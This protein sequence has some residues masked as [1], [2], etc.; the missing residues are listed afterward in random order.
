MILAFLAN[1][2]AL[3]PLEKGGGPAWLT[4]A[5]PFNW[6]AFILQIVFYLM[7][8][9][10]MKVKRRGWVGKLLYLP[11]F[12]VNSNLAAILGLY[13]FLSAKQTVVWKKAARS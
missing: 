13:R 12:L 5:A 4:L 6:I 7:A 2:A 11:T 1:L 10:G 9:V 3:L 8:W